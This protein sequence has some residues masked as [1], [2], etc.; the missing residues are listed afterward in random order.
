VVKQAI[1]HLKLDQGNAGKLHQLDLLSVPHMALLQTYCDWL[2]EHEQKKPNT[3]QDLPEIQTPLSARWQRCCWQQ[4]CGIVQSWFSNERANVPQI[5]N[6]AIQANANVVK[7]EKSNTETFDFW[8]K[9]ST[10]EKGKPVRIPI[11]LYP[12]A[13]ETFAQHPDICTGVLLKRD[14]KGVWSA[15][16]I[17]TVDTVKPEPAE[18]I[19][20]DVGM[21]YL[22]TTSQGKHYGAIGPALTTRI[23][24]QTETTKRKQKLSRCLKKKGLPEIDRH[25]HQA[26]SFCRN[27]IGKAL[28][29]LVKELPSTAAVAVEALDVGSMR[30]KSKAGNRR[31]RT[32]QLGY[33]K[34]KLQYKLEQRGFVWEAVQP[35][36]SS[37]E[38][39]VCGFVS[40]EN[41]KTQAQFF[42]QNCGHKENADTQASRTI[43]KRFGDRELNGLGF[44][45]VK[46]LLETRF[47]QRF[48]DGCRPSAGLDSSPKGNAHSVQLKPKRACHG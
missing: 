3:F 36:Y 21:S 5:K 29:R 10:L 30:F 34:D 20:I 37:Q 43:A 39:S 8:L 26:E 31:L 33:L 16:L 2:I 28:N 18:T 42:C 7:L 6:V 11:K 17:V 1:T 46:A 41:R 24:K 13:K 25:G 38:C 4:A 15:T 14:H 23:E 48:P 44:R 9:I 32:A 19:G 40:R 12:H 35:A 47:K 27:E 45:Q 22:A